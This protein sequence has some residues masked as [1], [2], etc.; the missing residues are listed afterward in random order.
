MFFAGCQLRCVFCQNSE[1]SASGRSGIAMDEKDLARLFLIQQARGAH[2]INLVTPTHYT[3][4]IA[5]AIDVSRAEGL[6][7]PVVWNSSAYEKRET[8]ALLRNR[9]DIYLPD[10]KYASPELAR[11]YSKAEDYPEIAKA[12]IDEMVSQQPQCVFDDDGAM[13]KG[14]IVR[15]LL[16]PGAV[17][18]AKKRVE[19]IYS[20]YGDS[21]YLSL[22]SQYTPHGELSAYPELCRTVTQEEYDELI[23]F[24]VDLGVT[25]GFTQELGAAEESFI[26]S[27]AGEG[28]EEF[29][30]K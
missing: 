11:R 10:Y 25:Q 29:L 27:F 7:L 14:V 2:N 23:D 18:D 6:K 30:R 28:L 26:P 24:A 4:T 1:I 21:V 15:I 3:D 17:D 19:Y 20:R 9:A 22:M 8:L 16:L 5:G 12:A 13:L